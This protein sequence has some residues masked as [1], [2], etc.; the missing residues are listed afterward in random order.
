MTHRK[1]NPE[2]EKEFMKRF[3]ALLLTV[4]MLAGLLPAGA[5]ANAAEVGVRPFYINNMGTG[6]KS[7]EYVYNLPNMYTYPMNKNTEWPRVHLYGTDDVDEMVQSMKEDFNSRPKGTRYFQFSLLHTAFFALVEDVAYFDK[8][9]DMV[10]TWLT[11]FLTKYKA[12]GGEL[13]GIVVDLEYIET[14]S[15]YLQDYYEGNRKK[16]KNT[17]IYADIVEN[18]LYETL[19]RPKLVE[20]GFKFY[21]NPEGDK[22]EIWCVYPRSGVKGHSCTGIWNTV[23]DEIEREC[24]NEAVLEPLLKFYPDAYLS[25]YQSGTFNGWEKALDNFGGI[26]STNVTSAGN[27]ANYNSYSCRPENSFYVSSGKARYLNP[28]GYNNAVYE[29]SAFKMFMYDVNL[30]K[31]MYAST[32]GGDLSI[33]VSDHRY[34]IEDPEIELELDGV[35]STFSLTPY[36]SESVFHFAMFD[37]KPFLGFAVQSKIEREGGDMDECMT[38]MNDVMAEITRVLGAADRKPIQVPV[39]WNGDFVLSGMYAGGRNVW[40]I[41]PD[42]TRVSLQNFKIKDKAPTFSVNG[43]TITFPQGRIIAD[44]NISEVGTC[45]YWVETPAN[46]TPVITSTA[47]R[48]SDY[49]SFLASFEE[50]ADNTRFDSSTALP[51][52]CWN[53]SG[54]AVVKNTGNGKALSISGATVIDNVQLPKNISAGD[55]YAKQQVWEVSFTLPEGLAANAELTLLD[56]SLDK[57]VGVKISGGNVYYSQKGSYQQLGG[58]SLSAGTYTLKRELDFRTAGSYTSSYAIYD[59]NGTLLGEAKDVPMASV[60]LPISSIRINCLNAN[61]PILIDNYKLYPTGVTTVFELF[62]GKTGAELADTTAALTKDSGYRMSWM[63][64]SS[65]YKVA[66]IYDTATKNVIKKVEMA[67]GMDGFVTGELKIEGGKSMTLAVRVDDATAPTY[68]NYDTGKFDWAPYA[69]NPLSN[70]TGD[71]TVGGDVGGNIGGNIDITLPGDAGAD[72]PTDATL[73]TLPLDP[74]DPTQPGGNTEPGGSTNKTGKKKMNSVVLALIVVLCSAIVGGG[75]AF[76]VYWFV[77]KPKTTKGVKAAK[78]TIAESFAEAEQKAEAE[79]AETEET[80]EVETTE[81]TDA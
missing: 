77:L 38:V 16:E 57:D 51:E 72:D 66:Y 1:N 54:E 41:T 60:E 70:M 46:V 64:A 71:S 48:Y 17:H 14:H 61:A 55:E 25:D 24:I 35:K 74:N 73:G 23:M 36:Y 75:G 44:G 33:W 20:R 80:P 37:P 40:R 13:D 76:A 62:D 26:R 12:I 78:P 47:S 65:D 9:V 42:T 10:K 29:A 28:P 68:P 59:A 39:S 7:Y 81:P 79:E 19:I 15:W 58:V 21:E 34:N 30:F 50:Y 31:G 4:V 69:D 3:L 49:P 32:N 67:P 56:C 45:G 18:P 11:E 52:A 2:K 63:N 6:G 27:T 5:V 8:A 53:V 22:S 43:Q